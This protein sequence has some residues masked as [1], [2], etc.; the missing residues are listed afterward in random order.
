MKFRMS[1]ACIGAILAGFIN[2]QGSSALTCTASVVDG[3]PEPDHPEVTTTHLICTTDDGQVIN[4]DGSR[5]EI[6]SRNDFYSGQTQLSLPSEIL[7]EDSEGMDGTYV[8]VNRETLDKIKLINQPQKSPRGGLTTEGTISVLVIIV[9]DGTNNAPTKK[10]TKMYDD[11]FGDE[12]NL[13]SLL[14]STALCMCLLFVGIL[15]RQSHQS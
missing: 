8:H 9:T 1:S 10:E 3:F 13:V 4:I 12:S 15:I 11:V 5:E 2:V 14:K 7:L 6:L